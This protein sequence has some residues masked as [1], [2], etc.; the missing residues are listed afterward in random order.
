M[1][2]RIYRNVIANA[3]KQSTSP[4]P[5]TGG[6][7]GLFRAVALAMTLFVLFGWNISNAFAQGGTAGPLTW[8]LNNGT[9]TI[10][11]EG[12]MP[13][14]VY[15]DDC[16][17]W[18]EYRGSIHTVVMESGVTTIGD[19]AFCLHESLTSC[20]IPGSVTTIGTRAFIQCL[21][22]P[23]ITIP[24]GVTSIARFVFGNCKSLVSITLPNSITTIG[25]IAFSWCYSL[26]SITLPDNLTT[27][28]VRAFGACTSLTSITIPNSVTTIEEG[29]FDGCKSL[30]SVILPDSITSISAYMFLACESLPSITIP[31]SV[32]FIGE[33]AFEQCKNMTSITL[34][35]G[36]TS[37]SA[38]TFNLCE[39]LTSITIPG[40]VTNIGAWAF[41]WCHSLPS[42][43]LPDNIT[44]I[45]ERTF[46]F[47]FNLASIT[48]P[49]GVAS[50]GDLAFYGCNSLTS[51]TIP[52][53]VTTIGTAVFTG[54]KKLTSVTIANGVKSIGNQAFSEC[55]NLISIINLNPNP[56]TINPN[57]FDKVNQSA[58]TLKVPMSSV[59]EYKNA[60]VW[61]NFN[62]VGIYTV[63]VSV[64]N[65]EYGTVTGSGFYEENE[66]VTV[67][68]IANEGYKFVS[69]TEDGWIVSTDSLYSFSATEDVELVANFEVNV[70]I[71]ERRVESGE[72]RVF[73]N[74]ASGVV[75]IA[76]AAEIEQLNIFDITGRLVASQTP[77][78]SQVTFD[79][80]IL[81]KGVY[82]VQARLR[83]GG[84][85]TG[86]VVVR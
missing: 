56:V 27:I 58:C 64:N 16:A 48:I 20:T 75:T 69:W 77:A 55:T 4:S 51:I 57:V 79:T 68:A 1:K 38:Y 28:G 17:P 66:T 59:S 45:K 72:L 7:F 40:S 2:K 61:K 34:P 13:D 50:I 78:N 42:I 46:I 5:S 49:D 24:D 25:N 41:A 22:L 14:Y 31:N 54:C 52:Q 83:D 21:S 43:T 11:G 76:A 86:K 23:S 71:E 29:A 74:P 67:T 39:N 8:N 85:Q 26:S 36:I 62:I 53:N 9:L 60:D 15:P 12:A 65:E 47:C 73:P 37:I 84:V 19:D 35:D 44:S 30:T 18:F 82:L 63:D 70:G 6:E 10:S 32:T 80:G 33:N 3:V 81:P